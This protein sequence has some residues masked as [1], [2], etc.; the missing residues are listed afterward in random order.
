MHGRREE[1]LF[2]RAKRVNG[3]ERVFTDPRESVAAVMD[4]TFL[5][6][7]MYVARSIEQRKE[8][9]IIYACMSMQQF[10]VV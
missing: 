3:R 6:T 4:I 2:F 7:K 1:C 8:V 10:V 5:L 9:I